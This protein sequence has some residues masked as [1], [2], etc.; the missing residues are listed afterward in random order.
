MSWGDLLRVSRHIFTERFAFLGAGRSLPWQSWQEGAGVLLLQVG[1]D[2]GSGDQQDQDG[3]QGHG[4]R[5]AGTTVVRFITS[6]KLDEMEVSSIILQLIVLYTFSMRGENII[7][8]A[9]QIVQR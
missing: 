8:L 3:H 4:S 6:R 1:G 7:F 5:H 9:G 2:A